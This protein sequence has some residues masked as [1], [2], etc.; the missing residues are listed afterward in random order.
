MSRINKFEEEKHQLIKELAQ[1]LLPLSSDSHKP[2]AIHQIVA[3][4]L[5]SRPLCRRFNGTPLTG[6]YQEI[7]LRV[8]EQLTKHLERQV[9][10]AKNREKLG[11]KPKLDQVTVPYLAELQNNIFR[12]LI[13]DYY[14]KKM[15]LAAQ[16]FPANSELRT[17]ALTELIRAIKFSGRLCKPHRKKFS[18]ELYRN[19]YEE[20]VTETLCYVCLN[21]DSYDP[22]RGNK[23]FMNWVNFKLDKS[24]LKC[25]EKYNSYARFE[26]PSSQNLEQIV[27]PEKNSDLTQKLREYLLSNPNEI[28]TKPHIRNR[29]DANFSRVALEKFSGQS[30]EEISQQ[31]DIPV[32]TLS[33]FYNRWCRRFAPLLNTELK[34]YL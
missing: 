12:R 22:E 10:V 30:W 13:D 21:I 16:N 4:I 2:S 5:R 15:G 7:Y 25:Y 31:L 14:L 27:Q 9:E 11:E 18:A 1:K 32:P 24:L 19:L 29:P 26:I 17:Y 3:I 8:K 34:Q 6:V 20:A 28:F 33:S 23:K